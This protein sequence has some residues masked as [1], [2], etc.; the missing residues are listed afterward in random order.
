MGS[1]PIQAIMCC[2]ILR[3][4]FKKISSKYLVATNESGLHLGKN[5]NFSNN[6]AVF[7]KSKVT[8]SN[9]Y[10]EVAPV[11]A[12]E[13]DI[14]ADLTDE[15]AL[16]ETDYIFEK[17]KNKK[18][19]SFGTQFVIWFLT[20]SRKIIIVDESSEWRIVDFDVNIPLIEGIVMNLQQLITEENIET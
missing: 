17:S 4:L 2:I 8:P 5:N 10:F 13:V 1:S 11:L 16:S 3:F 14:R 6:I 12:I 19:I 18:M 7:E 20:G 9:K 15:D